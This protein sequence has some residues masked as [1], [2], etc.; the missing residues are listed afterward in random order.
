MG[1]GKITRTCLIL[2]VLASAPGLGAAPSTGTLWDVSALASGCCA[3]GCWDDALETLD[4]PL[5]P[6]QPPE[7]SPP[8]PKPLVVTR[9]SAAHPQPLYTRSHFLVSP[10]GLAAWARGR[11]MEKGPAS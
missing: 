3:G 10:R 6:L 4:G 7:N 2:G 1:N 9:G 5:E 8:W 11:L